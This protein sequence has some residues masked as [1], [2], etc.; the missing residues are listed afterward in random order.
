MLIIALTQSL[1]EPLIQRTSY[2]PRVVGWV[3][4][5]NRMTRI[6]NEEGHRLRD[7]VPD[8]VPSQ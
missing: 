1:N 6:S 3:I 4:D 2:I 7:L 5:G 8:V